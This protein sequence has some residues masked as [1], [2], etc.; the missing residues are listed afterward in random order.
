MPKKS[1]ININTHFNNIDETKPIDL[2]KEQPFNY[3]EKIRKTDE[4]IDMLEKT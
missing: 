2:E 1:L 4:F 3:T